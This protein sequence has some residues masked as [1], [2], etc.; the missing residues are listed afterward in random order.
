MPRIRL[1]LVLVFVASLSALML[2][3]GEEDTSPTS[4]PVFVEDTAVLSM[5]ADSRLSGAIFTT[6]PDGSIVN[7]NTHYESKLEVYLDGGPPPNAPQH[8]A[9][10]PDGLYVFQITDPPG[11]VLLSEDPAKCRVVR[12]ENDII[13][14]L[15][16][17]SEIP[18]QYGGP[19]SDEYTVGKGGNAVTYPCSY[20]DEPD[21][22]AGAR[23]RHDTNTDVD[24][25][26]SSA[27]APMSA[28]KV[29]LAFSTSPIH[30]S[31]SMPESRQE[32]R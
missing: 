15:V 22:A 7:E 8:A 13:V 6:T 9:G 29:A 23:G 28:A 26:I 14:D 3:C 12:I 1:F 19:F 25:A 11:K 32:F 5:R 27:L 30:A 16:P 24:T 2:S 21:G 31:Q 18:T 17:P 10:L 20:Q 4:A